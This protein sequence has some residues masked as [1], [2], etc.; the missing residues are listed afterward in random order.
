MRIPAEPAVRLDSATVRFMSER[1][2]VTALEKVSVAI[3]AGGFM[4][5]LGPSG[6]GKSTLLR[7]VADL[8]PAAEGQV[9]VLGGTPATARATRQLGFVFQDPTLLPWRSALD[10]VRLPF[11][12]GPRK[13]DAGGRRTPEELL[14]LVGLGG[15]EAALPHELSGGMRQRVAI[16]RALV[17][18]PRLLL[19]D[20]PFGALDEITRDS[21]NEEL[22]RIW[23]DTGTTI[24]FV[25]HSIPEAVFLS[26]QVL[27]L[28]TNPGRVRELVDCALP[29]PRAL[30]DPR[31]DRLR[32]HRRPPARA[33]ADV[34]MAVLDRAVTAA[35]A[36]ARPVVIERR[37]R[38]WRDRLPPIVAALGLLA[39]WQ[40]GAWAFGLPIYIAP[41][42]AQVARTLVAELPILLRNFLPTAVE[43]FVGFLVGNT[44]GDPAGRGLRPQQAPGGGLLSDRGL[45]Q[46][47]P[48]P[49]Q[50]ADP[51]PDLRARDDLQGRDR[52][53]HLLLPDAGE[54]GARAPS[55]STR[56]RS[57]SCACSRRAGPRCS[58]SSGC[59]ARCRSSSRPSRSPPRPRCWGPSSGSGSAPISGSAPSIIEATHN[60]R[61]PLLYATIFV[62]SGWAVVFFAVV[63]FVERRVVTWK[64]AEAH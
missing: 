50:G 20:E 5:L 7:L 54:H 31:D 11:E 3:P 44:V 2:A 42:P 34:L 39:A 48:G 60:F 27:V 58:G 23:Q 63:S 28:A 6:C 38:S 14:R 47:H 18:E 22:L 57:S 1:G 8:V 26:Q 64:P 15:R 37:R 35:A 43:S 36:G 45:R 51:R 56:S 59:R 19:M 9:T 17:T 16:A 10:N 41:T 24:L 55:R 30:R 52:R 33:P 62:A 12:V 40:L 21:L 61:S 53:V 25:T 4:T 13:G 46:H 49:G 29:Y 32:A